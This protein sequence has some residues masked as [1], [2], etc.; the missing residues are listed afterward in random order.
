MALGQN[1]K[2]LLLRYLA[3]FPQFHAST[4]EDQAGGAEVVSE[5]VAA[6]VVVA[7]ARRPFKGHQ[8]AAGEARPERSRRVVFGGGGDAGRG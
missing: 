6:T 7:I 5:D 4:V 1:T 3:V 2:L 8:L